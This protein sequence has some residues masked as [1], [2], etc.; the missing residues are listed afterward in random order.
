MPLKKLCF[1]VFLLL[2]ATAAQAQYTLDNAASSL[3]FITIKKNKIGEVQSFTQLTGSI[4]GGVAKVTVDLTSVKTNIDI[5][6]ERLKS[7]LFETG[8]FPTATVSAQLDS[9]QLDALS[10]GEQLIIPV[11]LTLDLHGKSKNIE[12]SLQVIALSDGA[13]LVSTTTPVIINAFDFSLSEG[14]AKLMEAAKLPSISA[15]VP[16]TFSVI[17]RR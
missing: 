12:T 8:L 4:V 5:R 14:V 16:V 11:S 13:L 7:M 6:D 9:V 10:S 15:A 1:L 17:F 2:F 3:N